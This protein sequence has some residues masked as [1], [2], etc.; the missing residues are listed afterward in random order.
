MRM[1]IRRFFK[2]NGRVQGIGYRSFACDT[3]QGLGLTGWVCNLP[4]GAVE[5][6]VQGEENMVKQF[7]DELRGGYPLACV[8]ELVDTELPAVEN[9]TDFQIKFKL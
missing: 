7:L 4:G 8:R 9:E 1:V 2:L 3:A 5:G 6:E